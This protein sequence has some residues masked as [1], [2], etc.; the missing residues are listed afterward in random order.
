MSKTEFVRLVT[1]DQPEAPS[2]FSYDSQLNRKKHPTLMR[3]LKKSLK[4]LS[5]ARTLRLR[6][7]GAVCLDTREPGDFARAHLRGSLN[8]GL[9]GR[10]ANWAGILLDRRK[11]LIVIAET[12]SEAQAI[13]RLGRIGFDHVAGYLKGGMRALE[14]RG[15]LIASIERID[16]GTLRSELNS[17]RRPLVVDV[18]NDAERKAQHIAG[19]LHIP[20]NQLPRRLA[21]VPR[22]GVIV[23][24]CASGY[25]SMIA[26]SLLEKAGRE[27]LRDLQG[28]IAAWE[29]AP[30]AR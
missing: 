22:Q 18:R 24:H 10:F 4:P 25:R 13:L 11:P 20:L 1:A 6:E 14:K 26:A 9:G 15:D 28:G 21:E 12:G 5:L 17:R 23:I 27:G 3:A 8:I 7:A 19:S 30:T 29:A 2:Y 16:A